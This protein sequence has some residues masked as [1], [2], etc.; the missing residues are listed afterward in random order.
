[1]N[2]SR[3]SRADDPIVP[4][5]SKLQGE[6]LLLGRKMTKPLIVCIPHSLG[7]AEAR[8]RLKSRFFRVTGNLPI[9][10][11]DEQAWTDDRLTFRAHAMGQVASGTVD[12][13]ERDVRLEI[14]LPWCCKGLRKRC[15]AFKERTKLLLDK[16]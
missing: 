8:R 6:R 9:L 15:S 13:G 3:F 2:A 16:K 7:K 1:M 4:Q 14:V 11:F 5:P 12:V 10:K